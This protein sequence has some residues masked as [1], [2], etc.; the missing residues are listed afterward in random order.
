MK[1]I[2]LFILVILLAL[3]LP[4]QAKQVPPEL[5]VIPDNTQ[6]VLHFD[7][8]KFAATDLYGYFK[9]IDGGPFNKFTHKVLN[10]LNIDFMKDVSWITVFGQ[11]LH[12]ENAAFCCKGKFDAAHLISLVEKEITHR[13]IPY[14]KHTIHAWGKQFGAFVG[15]IFVFAKHE[16]MIK[17]VLDAIDGKRKAKKSVTPVSFLTG[18]PTGTFLSMVADDLPSIMGNHSRTFIL[19]QTRMAFFMAMEKSGN[20]NMKLKMTAE[21]ADAARNIEQVVRGFIAMIKLQH[22][23]KSHEGHAHQYAHALK[24]LDD[25]KIALDGNILKMELSFPSK[26]LA[27]IILGKKRLF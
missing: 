25:L 10:K 20:L 24:Y 1:R 4:S 23:E 13:K 8:Q 2:V 19:K 15:P 3:V 27:D 5:S 17:N 9:E 6:W 7:V 26:E 16:N 22:D 21:S 12:N 14:R 18:V 11:R